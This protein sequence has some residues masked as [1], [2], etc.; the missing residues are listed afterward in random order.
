MNDTLS[1]E[2]T[3]PTE[4][5]KPVA[6]ATACSPRWSYSSYRASLKL[7]GKTFALVTPDGRNALKEEDAKTLLDALNSAENDQ[8]DS[9]ALAD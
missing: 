8:G 7:D 2:E 9:S 5:G 3:P 6:A 4:S 1:K